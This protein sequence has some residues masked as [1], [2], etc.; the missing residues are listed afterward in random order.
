MQ[1]SVDKNAQRGILRSCKTNS[2]L[3]EHT[4][5]FVRPEALQTC[6]ERSATHYVLG[7]NTRPTM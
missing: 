3:L 6:Q 5:V 7:H 2:P 4:A 1:G